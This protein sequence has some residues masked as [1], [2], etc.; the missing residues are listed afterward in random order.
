LIL[1]LIGCNNYFP[2][3]P[4][5]VPVPSHTISERACARR[6]S[7]TPFITRSSCHA[8][9]KH[10]LFGRHDGGYRFVGTRLG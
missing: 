8:I 7:Q 4:P 1:N 6:V 2:R 10:N 5:K 3:V 9:Q